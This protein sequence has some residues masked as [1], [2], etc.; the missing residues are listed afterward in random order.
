MH[1]GAFGGTEK[2]TPRFHSGGDDEQTLVAETR[3]QG[4]LVPESLS[5]DLPVLGERPAEYVGGSHR[6]GQRM[7]CAF[8]VSQQGRSPDM[9][10]C[11]DTLEEEATE[12]SP[13]V[14]VRR[15][16]RRR[17]E[18]STGAVMVCK[19]CKRLVGEDEGGFFVSAQTGRLT[20]FQCRCC[21]QWELAPGGAAIGHRG[22]AT[23]ASE[24]SV[25]SA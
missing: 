1:A 7:H 10:G 19:L 14:S 24:A 23:G 13:S 5:D 3:V 4:L 18:T 12:A 25:R 15:A 2:R 8:Q 21:T 9:T 17:K 22:R 16:R 11:V 6:D 20:D